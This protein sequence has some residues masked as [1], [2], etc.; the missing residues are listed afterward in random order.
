MLS[1]V[2][3]KTIEQ[4][5]SEFWLARPSQSCSLDV[6]YLLQLSEQVTILV[7]ELKLCFL[8]QV[9]SGKSSSTVMFHHQLLLDINRC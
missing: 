9:E 6:E 3:S 2:I 1:V 5:E 4:A 8:F 7:V